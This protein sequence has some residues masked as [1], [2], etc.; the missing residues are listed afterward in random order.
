MRLLTASRL[1]LLLAI[2]GAIAG[3]DDPEE[4]SPEFATSL[5]GNNI[6]L[7]AQRT[8][9]AGGPIQYQDQSSASFTNQTTPNQQAAGDVIR[10]LRLF[11]PTGEDSRLMCTVPSS[12]ELKSTFRIIDPET[13][14][15]I[16][17]EPQPFWL[18]R[19]DFQSLPINP[20]TVDVPVPQW[21]INADLPIGADTAEQLI[22]TTVLGYT[23]EVLATP[24][25]FTW[26]FHNG[27]KPTITTEVSPPYPNNTI[28]AVYTD[29]TESTTVTLTTTWS[30]Q[31]R[32][33]GTSQW[34]PI[35]GDATTTA[36][37]APFLIY[38]APARLIPTN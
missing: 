8:T 19:S 7:D 15:E 27:E 12:T 5:Q 26:D 35:V 33:A 2:I 3:L 10:C 28:N 18:S 22:T 29:V 17:V 14:E 30:G 21:I 34:L 23:V 25:T 38:E 16:T 37:S 24:E 1:S 6:V 31:W 13:G 4:I 9:F 32:I 20:G 11:G 36:E